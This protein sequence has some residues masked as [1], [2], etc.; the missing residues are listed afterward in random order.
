M[1]FK[2]SARGF[3]IALVLMV[4][5]V[6]VV[7]G[8]AVATLGVQNLGFMNRDSY[9][10]RAFYVAEAGLAKGIAKLKT[11]STWDGTN[12]GTEKV[13]TFS[14]VVLQP[15][16]DKYS[17][18]VFN[19]FYGTTSMANCFKG[20]TVP[21]GSCYIVSEG[22]SGPS[23]KG[24]SSKYAAVMINKGTPFDNFGVFGDKSVTFNGA[25]SIDAYDSSTGQ[26]K[27]G[28]GDAGTNGNQEGAITMH[29]SSGSVDGTL[30]AGP[31]SNLGTNGA[32]TITGHPTITGGEQ[33]LSQP[34]PMPEVVLPSGLPLQNLPSDINGYLD[35]KY[36]FVAMSNR[37]SSNSNGN[38]NSNSNGN[39]NSGSSSSSNTFTLTPANYN[40][41]LN[42]SSQQVVTLTGPGTYIFKGIDI[43]GQGELRVDTTNGPVKIYVDGSVNMTGGANAGGIFNQNSNGT[44][45]TTDLRI[46]G[47]A[48]C[49]NF[50]F[51]GHSEAYAGIYAPN[52]DINLRGNGTVYGALIGKTIWIHGNPEFHYDVALSKLADDIKVIKVD[53]WQR[54]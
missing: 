30:Y 38:G 33:V 40:G 52:A 6:V 26:Q 43:A 46:Y 5:S 9:N 49:T 29:G 35:M 50:D 45:K 23:G 16:T 27:P 11:D 3:S 47:T 28:E 21:A 24:G 20:I 36:K 2:S 4:I 13:Q 44:P 15:G 18:Q 17:V 22:K 39:G 32:I 1:K 48:N 12:G 54:F 19:N 53:S 42:I 10:T 25:I 8:I 14:D 37:G 7:I 34:N 41:K 31:G 51:R